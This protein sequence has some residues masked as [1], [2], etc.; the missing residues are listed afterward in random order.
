MSDTATLQI[1]IN[2]QQKGTG[3]KDAEKDLTDVSKSGDQANKDLAKV[4]LA[5]AAVGA[6][7]TLYAKNA[8][9][10]TVQLASDTKK[11]S[12]E[13][14]L[15]TEQASA[16]VY[17]TGRLG[18]DAD[19]ASVS[20]GIFSKKIT[21]TNQASD[22]AT[23]SLGKLHVA[24]QNADGSTRSFNDILLST[25]DQFKKMPDGPE[26]TAL[27]LD[28]FG[29]SG[30]DMIK[31]LNLGSDGIADL[32]KKAAELGL[33]L[34]SQ[35]ISS[36][37]KYIK[38]QKDLKDSTNALKIQIG[39]LTTPI[40]TSF[41]QHVNSVVTALISTNSPL[42]GVTANVLA[43]GGPLLTVAGGL[44][45]F[46]SNLRTTV[47]GMNLAAIGARAL[48]IAMGPVGWALLAITTAVSGVV[49]WLGRHKK[50][51]DDSATSSQNQTTISQELDQQMQN[52]AL[53]T[54]RY[55]QSLNALHNAQ[56]DAEGST[57]AVERAQRNYTEAVKEHGSTSL[58][59]REAEY[60]LKTAQD[61]LKDSIDKVVVAQQ[62][63]NLADGLLVQ[64]TPAVIDALQ[65]RTE[66]L[67]PIA[68]WAAKAL[69]NTTQLDV[70][71]GK[72][73]AT[74]VSVANA[75][76][77]TFNSIQ[78]SLN[79]I[80]VSSGQIQE[81][82]GNI[83]SSIVNLDQTSRSKGIT[84]TPQSGPTVS[85]GHRAKGG[86]VEAGQPYKV[87]EQGEELFIP[88]RSGTIVPNNQLG[89]MT[90]GSVNFNQT[91]N[92]FNN[93]DM[94]EANAEIGWRLASA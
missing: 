77:P 64:N 10:Y 20:F 52:I 29:R 5:I 55:T 43:F 87:G 80:Q 67:K 25:A 36:V 58:E 53:N 86:P 71:L 66:A 82:V 26:K 75:I 89:R 81:A 78:G 47:A 11:L 19:Q 31:V 6:G 12:R 74:A 8:T 54:D 9:D 63:Q 69:D 85:I 24:V 92:I 72:L 62:N 30:K 32:E 42:R 16:L 73:P 44:I 51:T 65:L 46:T 59:A 37:S 7:I 91:N 88:N 40:L 48:E 2:S 84:L 50:A 22:P 60:N 23:T 38:S 27:A 57:L 3:L 34:N 56:L 4:G 94:R 49:W 41:N 1:A 17:A 15:A 79:T 35:T 39:E 83:Q 18:I 93:T 33:T 90:G 21:E 28:L 45:S 70:A 76:Q 68:S 14:G 61:H 13:T